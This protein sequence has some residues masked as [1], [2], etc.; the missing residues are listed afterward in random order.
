MLFPATPCFP[1]VGMM[2]EAAKVTTKGKSKI[3]VVHKIDL[4][5]NVHD[6][7]VFVKV[8]A[9]TVWVTRSLKTVQTNTF[10]MKN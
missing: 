5:N 1:K 8:D 4:G 6:F 9:P 2:H 7:Q 10:C 3:Y